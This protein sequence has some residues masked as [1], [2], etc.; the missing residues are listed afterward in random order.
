MVSLKYYKEMGIAIRKN[1]LKNN[2]FN[3]SLDIYQDGVSKYENLKL[4]IHGNPKT[5][6]EKEHNRSTEAL[7]EQIKAKR[8]LEMQDGRFN[9]HSGFKSQGS[10]IEYFKELTR[11]RRRSEGNYGNWTSALKHLLRFCKGRNLKFVDCDEMFLVRFREFL[12]NENLTKS[13]TKLSSNSASSYLNKVKAALNQAYLDK[14]ILDSPTK[15]VKSIKIEDNKREYLLIE[16]VK[17][18]SKTDCRIP[19]LKQAFLFS[20]LTGLRWSDINK[21]TWKELIF[22]E[23]ENKWKIH[24][25]QKKTKDVQYHPISNEAF[26]LLG[27]KGDDNQKVFK[28]LRYSAWNNSI[29]KE[30]VYKDAGVNKSITFHCARHTYATL[31][32]TNGVDIYT[33]CS[34]LGH[35]DIKNTQIYARIIDSKKNNSIDLMPSIWN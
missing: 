12:L 22:S 18:L 25:T 21:L 15:R 34:L 1:K 29:L 28:G 23:S 3:L 5:K 6:E 10:F 13:N 20:C 8:I 30:W 27:K 19:L 9:I 14:I 33:V 24:F 7:A 16:E 32:L 31:L 26:S 35:K 11:Q 17:L 4:Y 2:R